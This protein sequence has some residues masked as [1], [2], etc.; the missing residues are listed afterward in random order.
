MAKVDEAIRDFSKAIELN[1]KLTLAYLNR[2]ICYSKKGNDKDAVA[3]LSQFIAMVPNDERGYSVRAAAYSRL[4][5]P[6][7]AEADNRKAA[8]LKSGS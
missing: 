1:S 8:Q 7:K 2:G 6:E 3:D 5:E 4:G